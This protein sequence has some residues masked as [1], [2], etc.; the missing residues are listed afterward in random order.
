MP[1][2]HRSNPVTFR[3]PEADRAWLREHAEATG[4]PAGAILTDAL[5]LYRETAEDAEQA[6]EIMR[7]RMQ[8]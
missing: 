2:K 5:R 7:G 1:N 4:R 3:P 6:A 8:G